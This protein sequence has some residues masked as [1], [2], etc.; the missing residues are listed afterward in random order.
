MKHR[1]RVKHWRWIMSMGYG[2]AENWYYQGVLTQDQ[3]ELYN[4]IWRNSAPRF[5]DVAADYDLPGLR[6]LLLGY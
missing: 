5:S 3:W 2:Q 4:T 6:R 1:D